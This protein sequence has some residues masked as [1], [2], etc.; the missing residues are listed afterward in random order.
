MYKY[1]FLLVTFIS[2]AQSQT[3]LEFQQALERRL[4]TDAGLRALHKHQSALTLNAKAEIAFSATEFETVLEDFGQAEIEIAARQTFEAPS[5][6][7]NK[8]ELFNTDKL[9]LNTDIS[10]YR[11]QVHY[12]LSNYFLK[13]FGTHHLLELV[14]GRLSILNLIFT[15]QTKRFEAGALAESELIRSRLAVAEL[16]AE[17]A[18]I[19]FLLINLAEEFSIYLELPISVDMLPT[20]LPPYANAE[21][22]NLTWNRVEEAPAIRYQEAQVAHLRAGKRLADTP[23]ITSLSVTAGLKLLPEFSQRVPVLGFS[24]ESP[25]FSQRNTLVQAK[26]LE[27]Q[28]SLDDMEL[29]KSTL[30]LKKHQWLTE[31]D[32]NN[33]QLDLLQA[34]LIPE[35]TILQEQINQEYR[36]GARQYLDVLDAQNLLT[37]LQAKALDLQVN[38]ATQLFEMNLTLGVKIYEFK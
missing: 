1:L 15:W 13:A 31:W 10:A 28:A 36:A 35:A 3:S 23:L 18:Q 11:D 20:E 27:I 6:R 14:K 30:K 26:E 4:T 21:T 16:S 8:L 24:L 2:L 19:E 34:T 9:R 22:L 32:M 5:I 33:S 29:I 37:D 7:K 25:L 12:Q 17:V 38:M